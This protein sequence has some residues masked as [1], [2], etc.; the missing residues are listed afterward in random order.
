M[1]HDGRTVKSGCRRPAYI[2][3]DRRDKAAG[4]NRYRGACHALEKSGL[5]MEEVPYRVAA[6]SAQVDIRQ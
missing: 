4:E 6:F 1:C 5:H 2:G 3:V